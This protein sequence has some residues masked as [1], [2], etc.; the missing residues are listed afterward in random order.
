VDLWALKWRSE[1]RLDGRTEHLMLFGHYGQQ[2]WPAVFMTRSAA[3]AF[4]EEKYGYIR[5]RPDLRREPHGW[6]LPSIVKVKIIE[7]DHA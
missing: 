3:R 1:C 2:H 6:K 4:R 5:R 7:V